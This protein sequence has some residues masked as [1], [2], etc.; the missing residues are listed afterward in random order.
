MNSQ[1]PMIL[2][3]PTLHTAPYW[4]GAARGELLLQRCKDCGAFRHP[5]TP[6]CSSCTSLETEW[7]PAG[8]RG[9]VFSY[10]IAHHVV[11]P[12]M[13]DKVPYAIV[14]IKLEEG[15][16]IISNLV[17]CENDLVR[18]GMPVEVVFEKMTDE[19]TLPKFRPIG[20]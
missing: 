7:V 14:L 4:E 9:E 19:V 16:Y 1:H 6:M 3:R 10:T 17:D 11:H 2:P 18:I 8:G 20:S 5:P 13:A 12:A 15:P